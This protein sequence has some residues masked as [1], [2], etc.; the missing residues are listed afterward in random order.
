MIIKWKSGG[1]RSVKFDP[2]LAARQIKL[3]HTVDLAPGLTPE[4]R[5]I[6]T[7]AVQKHYDWLCDQEARKGHTVS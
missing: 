5:K 4:Q 6:D 7:N 1:E 3:G 2:N